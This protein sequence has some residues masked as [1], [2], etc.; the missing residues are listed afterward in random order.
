[1]LNY[2]ELNK[3]GLQ[4]LLTQSDLKTLKVLEPNFNLKEFETQAEKFMI[5]IDKID[6]QNQKLTQFQSLLLSRLATLEG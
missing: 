4:A 5:M 6:K 2:D 3:G 1:M